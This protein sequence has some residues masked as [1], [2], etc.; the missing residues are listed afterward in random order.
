MSTLIST[1]LLQRVIEYHDRTKHHFDRHARSLG[2]LDWATQPDP[3][4][5]FEGAPLMPLRRPDL[6]DSPPY[7]A[8]F[9]S[10]S[11]EP[12]E[13]NEK[14]ISRFFFD[15]LA[16]SA[17]KE[18]QGARWALRVNPSSGNLHPTEGYLV[19]GPIEGLH[20]KPAVY[21]YAPKEHGLELRSEIDSEAWRRLMAFAPEGSFLFGLTSIHWREAWKYGERAFRYCQHDVGHAIGALRISAALLGWEARLIEDVTDDEIAQLLGIETQSGPEQ[22][23]PEC[24]GIVYPRGASLE[25]LSLDSKAIEQIRSGRWLGSPNELSPAHVPWEVIDDVTKATSKIRAPVNFG[26]HS[27]SKGHAPQSPPTG[28]DHDD[29]PARRL[30]H[31]RRSA[32]AMD[33][34]TSISKTLFYRMLERTIPRPASA[35]FDVIPWPPK[36]DLF[37]FVHRVDSLAPGLYVLLRDPTR[38]AAFRAATHDRFLWTPPPDCPDSISLFL[39]EEGDVRQMAGALSCGQ[40]IAADGAFSLGMIA[41]FEPAMAEYGPWFYRRLFWESGLI[42]QLLYLEAEAAGVQATGIG[43]FLDDPVHDSLGF[44]NHQFQSLYHFTIGGA[45][46]DDRLTTLPPYEDS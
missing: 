13:L 17:W 1:G 29:P 11:I 36:I 28:G 18:F 22:E 19:A 2:Y 46:V 32:V 9:E 6:S 24:L 45:V 43:C 16:L 25:R 15:A 37:L 3:F 39:L 40:A 33:G 12:S 31:Q 5:R 41:E 14:T 34:T 27:H 23:F 8:I 7:G 42:G 35:P 10:A 44:E 21:H 20:D 30:I 26:A 38:M 4:R